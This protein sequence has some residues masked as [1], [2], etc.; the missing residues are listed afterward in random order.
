MQ[1]PYNLELG[2]PKS[3]IIKHLVNNENFEYDENFNTLY[4]TFNLDKSPKPLANADIIISLDSEKV[5]N[6]DVIKELTFMIFPEE[7]LYDLDDE[8]VVEQINKD[9]VSIFDFFEELYGKASKEGESIDRETENK[10]AYKIW[11]IEDMCFTVAMD[12]IDDEDDFDEQDDIAYVVS[13]TF[14][15]SEDED[16]ADD[17]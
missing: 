8:N 11:V 12:I 16:I 7:E 10:T 4:G 15:L 17:E 9:Q 1:I 2:K 14:S 5:D 13:I 3:E 6:V